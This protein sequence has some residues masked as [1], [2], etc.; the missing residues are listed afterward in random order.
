MDHVDGDRNNNSLGN[1]KAICGGPGSCHAKKSSAEGNA[2]RWAGRK[3]PARP[4]P[5]LVDEGGGG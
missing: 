5:G 2:T 4:H 3:R 1:L